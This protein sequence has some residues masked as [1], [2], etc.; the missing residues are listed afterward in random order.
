M[1]RVISNGWVEELRVIIDAVGVERNFTEGGVVTVE[2]RLSAKHHVVV[3]RAR[4]RIYVA[5]AGGRVREVL[6]VTIGSVDNGMS[7]R[8]VRHF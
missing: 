7:D 6:G 4:I 8:E 3:N 1:Q 5:G 2:P